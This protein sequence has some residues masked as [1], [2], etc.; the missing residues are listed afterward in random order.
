VADFSLPTEIEG[1]PALAPQRHPPNPRVS[2]HQLAYLAVAHPLTNQA[3]QPSSPSR[4][5]RPRLQLRPSHRPS[6]LLVQ[7]PSAE[8]NHN[9][10]NRVGLPGIGERYLPHP[11]I[12]YCPHPH[13]PSPPPPPSTAARSSL[14]PPENTS[15]Q[16]TIQ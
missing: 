8:A 11:K 16:H 9:L 2:L 5:L 6:T 13:P 4:R 1:S 7:K 10:L 15:R 14:P 12:Y 3:L